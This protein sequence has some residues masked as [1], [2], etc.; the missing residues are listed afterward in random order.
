MS[1]EALATPTSQPLL[2]GRYRVTAQL[3][4][5]RLATVYAATD[6]RLR[7]RVLLMLLRKELAGQQRP[8]ERFLAEIG[9]MA[10]RSHPALL[11]VFD[12]GEVGGRPFVVT[13]HS[14]G[15]PLHGLGLLT[16]EQALLYLRQ[17]AGAVAVCQAQRDATAP[18]G[19]Y[20]PP[21]SSSNV[22]LVDE[23]RIKLVDSWLLPVD[24]QQSDLAHYRAPELSEGRPAGPASAVYALG[25]LL[26]ELI[27][28]E[29]PVRGA[30]ARATAL[31]HLSASIP[32]LRQARPALYLPSLE[33]LLARAT[34]RRPEQRFA[35]AQSLG[36]A[37]DSLWRDLGASTRPLGPPP[38]RLA[39]PVP[40]VAPP[41]AEVSAARPARA[42][43][44]TQTPPR[45]ALSRGSPGQARPLDMGAR[46]KQGRARNLIGWL[47]MVALVLG[48]AGASYLAVSALVGQVRGLPSP[49]SAGEGPLGWLGGLLG[50]D[51]EIYVVNIA[52]GLNLRREP[53]ASNPANVIAVVPNGATVRR[54]E[55]PQ[56]AGNIP[57]LRV[58]AEV[59]GRAVEGWMSMNYLL[60]QQ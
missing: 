48:V 28:G 3:G 33:A 21:I 52:A 13:E 9:Q 27:T 7:R 46:R 50:G 36:V 37:F 2:F 57:W 32:P 55:G 47:V 11:E 4:E 56:V 31:A 42:Q 49:P 10:R 6:E 18:Q 54:L 23:G 35:D 22:L 41:E 51:E 20:H 16:V 8:R 12:S 29:R 34:A 5:T 58:R 59:D 38:G 40:S 24:E 53:D 1:D 17:L 45:P 60:P 19:L 26:Y 15:R 39:P 14:L 25:L 43:T 30:D 44:A